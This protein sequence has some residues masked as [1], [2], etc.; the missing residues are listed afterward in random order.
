MVLDLTAFLI[1]TACAF[2]WV[3]LD[4]LRK[5][6]AGRARAL[7]ITCL[8]VLAQLPL[9]LL[10]AAVDGRWQVG[11]GYWLPGLGCIVVNL[12]ASLTYMQSVRRSG[13]SATLPLLSLTPVF[14]TLLAIPLL[15][16]WPRPIEAAGITVVVVGAFLL[17]TPPRASLGGWWQGV[18]QE[19]GAPWMVATALLWSMA[20]P[21]DKLAMR[22]ASAGLH[23]LIMVVGIVAG[24]W[25]V[26]FVR[27]ELG[28]LRGH[29]RRTWGLLAAAAVV[30]GVALFFQLMAIQMM[31]VGLVETFKRG[32]GAVMALVLGRWVFSEELSGRRLAAVLMM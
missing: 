26:L 12:G 11:T 17:N 31:W 16:E 5:L 21:F 20:P 6:L 3:G 7:P 24:L 30:A 22:H 10:W 29:G 1:L 14:T 19:K 4:L 27:G 15:A 25:S 32:V 23:A 18:S 28:E 13:M 8:M 9:F 2:A